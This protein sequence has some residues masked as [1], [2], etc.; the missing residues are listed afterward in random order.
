MPAQSKVSKTLPLLCPGLRQGSDFPH[1]GIA[2][3]AAAMG[4]PWPGAANPASLP[5]PL[6]KETRCA[7]PA[8]GRPQVAICVGHTFCARLQNQKQSASREG[9]HP[10]K[11]CRADLLWLLLFLPR[12][13]RRRKMR[14]GRLSGGAVG[15]VARHGCRASAAG[16]WM[17]RRRVPAP[18]YRRAEPLRYRG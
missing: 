7:I 8:L 10:G 13:P 6:N 18:R 11:I 2:P 4:H 12:F 17:A 1:S 5:L 3:W 16:P 14:V 9:N 15:W